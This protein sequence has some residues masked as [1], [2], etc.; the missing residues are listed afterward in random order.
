MLQLDGRIWFYY[1]WCKDKNIHF[2]KD[3]M[4]VWRRFPV[5]R[6]FRRRTVLLF[7]CL[8][9]GFEKK[10][11]TLAIRSIFL[12]K[13]FDEHRTLIKDVGYLLTTTKLSLIEQ[14]YFIFLLWVCKQPQTMNFWPVRESFEFERGVFYVTVISWKK[15]IQCVVKIS[16]NLNKT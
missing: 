9:I 10:E 8:V 14:H 6:N 7:D 4:L 5:T 12:R 1:C 2:E 15:N 11:S 13:I 3:L 16:W